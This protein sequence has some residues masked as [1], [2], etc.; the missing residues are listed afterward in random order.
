MGLPGV[1]GVFV[2]LVV[3][4]VFVVPEVTTNRMDPELSLFGEPT[5]DTSIGPVTG[6]CELEEH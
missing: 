6:P 3:N 1:D 2:L 4:E 5:T